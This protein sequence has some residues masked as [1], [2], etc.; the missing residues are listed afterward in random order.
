M[1]HKDD[2]EFI[3]RTCIHHGENSKCYK[4]NNQCVQCVRERRQRRRVPRRPTVPVHTKQM[5][6]AIYDL[7]EH[8]ATCPFCGMLT[9]AK[10]P[11]SNECIYRIA[12]QYL[13]P[14]RKGGDAVQKTDG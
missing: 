13:N 3:Y 5:A 4:S 8:S 6:Q 14:S 12:T 9:Y 10:E 7:C 2:T 1:R 11:H